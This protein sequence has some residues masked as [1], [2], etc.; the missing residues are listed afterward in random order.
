M[1][2]FHAHAVQN[3]SDRRFDSVRPH[4]HRAHV[5]PVRACSCSARARLAPLLR[6]RAKSEP[7]SVRSRADVF[8]ASAVRARPSFSPARIHIAHRPPPV[9]GT[10]CC[11][12]PACSPFLP[13]ARARIAPLSSPPPCPLRPHPGQ[14][15]TTLSPHNTMTA[16]NHDAAPRQRAAFPVHPPPVLLFPL[17]FS[18]P[19]QRKRTKK[20]RPKAAFLFGTNACRHSPALRPSDGSAFY[21]RSMSCGNADCGSG[22]APGCASGSFRQTACH[23]EATSTKFCT[24]CATFEPSSMRMDITP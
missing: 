2:V 19:G 12:I 9:P 18:P 4:S 24:H 21:T 6:P 17:L 23:S 7:A 3:E 22:C 15:R 10:L 5:R 11:P 16:K 14:R 13:P 8:P 20:D 1:Y